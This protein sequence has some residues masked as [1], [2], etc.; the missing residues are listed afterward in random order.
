MIIIIDFL[1]DG[2]KIVFGSAVV[3][4]FIPSITGTITRGVFWGG[5]VATIFLLG[6]AIV[7]AK[8][9]KVKI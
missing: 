5:V 6:L 7:L 3:G 2:A 9:F 4:F 1:K 8:K